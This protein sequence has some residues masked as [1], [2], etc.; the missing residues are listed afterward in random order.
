MAIIHSL[1]GR[2]CGSPRGGSELLSLHWSHED[3]GPPQRSPGHHSVLDVPV[4]LQP[5]RRSCLSLSET[6][7]LTGVELPWARAG[8]HAGPTWRAGLTC[9]VLRWHLS[10]LVLP[11]PTSRVSISSQPPCPLHSGLCDRLPQHPLGRSGLTKTLLP[12]SLRVSPGGPG[13]GSTCLPLQWS[14]GCGGKRSGCRAPGLGLE[15]RPAGDAHCAVEPRALPSAPSP[16]WPEQTLGCPQTTSHRA[17]V[18]SIAPDALPG[19]GADC[20]ERDG[21]EGCER[22]GDEPVLPPPG[23]CVPPCA[24]CPHSDFPRT[25]R[26]C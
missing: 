8:G 21:P 13:A 10:W 22:L 4:F 6:C 12:A 26:A 15:P 2:A 23:E 17:L 1:V 19:P 3:S 18:L 7:L 14:C 11:A 25:L 24:P 5:L 16:A 9:F 20:W